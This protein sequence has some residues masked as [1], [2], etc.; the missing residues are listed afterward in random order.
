MALERL[1]RIKT[2]PVRLGCVHWRYLSA[3]F[4]YCW[5]VHSWLQWLV[6]S[7]NLNYNLRV[8]EN[9]PPSIVSLRVLTLCCWCIRK[10]IAVFSESVSRLTGHTRRGKWKSLFQQWAHLC[11]ALCPGPLSAFLFVT[12]L[13]LTFTAAQPAFMPSLALFST[14]SSSF[15]RRCRSQRE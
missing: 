15:W 14:F 12:S 9:K 10:S 2:V 4:V 1:C 11:P 13:N 3:S 8:V 6:I 7:I 5:C